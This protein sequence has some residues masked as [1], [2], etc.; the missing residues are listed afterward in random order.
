TWLHAYAQDDWKIARNLSLNA[1]LRYEINS[2]MRDV[3]NRLSAIDLT[4]PGGRFVIASDDQGNLSP[5]AQPLLGEIPIAY[6]SSKDADWTPGLLRPSYLR[7]AP[8]AGM[9]WALGERAETVLNAGFGVFLNQWAYSV[10]QALA[11]TL[12]FFF[13]KTVN[14]AADA[15]Q[16]AAVTRT[17]LLA[18]ANGS[19]GGNTMNHDYRTEYAKNVSVAVQRQLTPTSAI[20]IGY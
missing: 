15:L 17:M 19:V 9:T 18:P 12:P 14:A 8:R 10:Q 11:Q 3:D 4:V 7:F 2:Q 16:P 6:G 5:S 1:G 20:E 13:A